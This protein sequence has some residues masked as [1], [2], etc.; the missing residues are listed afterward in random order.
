[1]SDSG[2]EPVADHLLSGFR[3]LF[4]ILYDTR[5]EEERSF[6]AY[7]HPLYTIHFGEKNT[8]SMLSG[9][10]REGKCQNL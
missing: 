5:A 2:D 4:F 7:G 3:E 8:I 9:K 1:M 10:V 6:L